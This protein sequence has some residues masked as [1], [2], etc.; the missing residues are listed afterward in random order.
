MEFV[1]AQNVTTD[2]IYSDESPAFTSGEILL[3][4][5]ISQ[6]QMSITDDTAIS[7]NTSKLEKIPTLI[8]EQYITALDKYNANFQ[9]LVFSNGNHVLNFSGCDIEQIQ[10]YRGVTKIEFKHYVGSSIWNVN[11][12]QVGDQIVQ[13]VLP[14]S[15]ETWA[16]NRYGVVS[17]ITGIGGGMFD[18]LSTPD[19]QNT[20]NGVY[21]FDY[22]EASVDAHFPAPFILTQITMHVGSNLTYNLCTTLKVY[23]TNDGGNWTEVFSVTGLTYTES[24]EIKLFTPTIQK[25]FK[26]YK[27][28]FSGSVSPIYVWPMT[29][30]GYK[31]PYIGHI[32]FYQFPRIGQVTGNYP[33]ICAVSM[34]PKEGFVES[35]SIYQCTMI[36]D[37]TSTGSRV[38]VSRPSI[39]T[40]FIFTYQFIEPVNFAGF[41]AVVRFTNTSQFLG[42]FRWEGSND[43]VNW[44]RLLE[45]RDPW[46]NVSSYSG[47]YYMRSVPGAYKYIRIVIYNDRDYGNTGFTAHELLPIYTVPNEY[48]QFDTIVPVMSSNSQDGYIISASSVTSGYVYN[49]YDG[50]ENTYC[51]GAISDGQWITTVDLGYSA[52]VKG[53]QLESAADNYTR[54]PVTFS[55][56]GSTDG[57]T[58]QMLQSY[59]L[60][61]NYWTAYKQIE[62][63]TINNT[64]GY[65]Y[66]RMVVTATQESGS[67]VRIARLGWTTYSGQT[68]INYWTEENLVPLMNSNSQDGYIAS[69]NSI[70]GATTDACKA[71]NRAVNGSYDSWQS[72]NTT[73]GNAECTDTWVQIQLPSAKVCNYFTLTPREDYQN[74]KPR[75][76]RAFTIEGS[77]NGTT[78]TVLLNVADGGQYSTAQSWNIDNT[79][80]YLYYRINITKTYEA[81]QYI[82][83]GELSFI[84]RNVYNQNFPSGTSEDTEQYL[85]PVMNSA[86]EGGYVATASSVWTNDPSHQPFLAFARTPGSRWASSGMSTAQWLKIQMPTA[87]VC[88]LVY[89][90]SR[91]DGNFRTSMPGNFEIQGSNDDEIWTTLTSVT[92]AT[93]SAEGQTHGYSFTNTTAY[94]Y[95][96]I[97]ITS[98][99]SGGDATIAR[100]DFMYKRS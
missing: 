37:N 59:T 44:T 78:W 6:Y 70:W 54:M 48:R 79:T 52:V 56:Q 28:S 85:V 47:Y 76:P 27:F 93:W 55:I 38:E 100:L 84:E 51:E 15:S 49:M 65:R 53:F 24:L 3:Q 34:N 74:C 57:N 64:T 7:I 94:L 98:V 61:G 88:N 32:N 97:Y 16:S 89:I 77:N 45:L 86:S 72:G 66:Y 4:D 39:T 19:A 9:L 62:S 36:G 69:A 21:S 46:L 81:N 18:Y 99:P 14:T 2:S 8:P 63:F 90:T 22:T 29:L 1:L 5:R 68:A 12:I 31:C 82:S 17:S 80:A 71:F 33:G 87:K 96:R 41:C 91:N 50:N 20:N 26:Q 30:M 10:V 13:Q 73:N 25:P 83:I 75:T 67:N 11:L 58:W 40:P 35:R 92:G 43:G 60:G 95:Y 42:W 23:G